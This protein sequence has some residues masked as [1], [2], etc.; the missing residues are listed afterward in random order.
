[1]IN[2]IHCVQPIKQL[3]GNPEKSYSYQITQ[4]IKQSHNQL[5][6]KV[7]ERRKEDQIKQRHREDKKDN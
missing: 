3:L 7:E 2:K 5:S 1:M 4:G 6:V